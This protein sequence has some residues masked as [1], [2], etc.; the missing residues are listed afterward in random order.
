[1]VISFGS[2]NMDL[3]LRCDRIP[4]AGET[5]WGTSWFMN[6]G[7]KGANQAVQA[8][9]LGART[10]FIGC[11]GTDMFGRE[12]VKALCTE[13]IDVS[14][15]RTCA[16]S[17]GAAHILV[18]P[19][20]ENR[21]VAVP[22]A[23]ALVGEQEIEV[24]R[25]MISASSVLLL[26]C[27]IPLAVVEKAA[28]IAHAVGATV[29]LDPAPVPPVG[30]LPEILADVDYVM[31]NESEARALTGLDDLEAAGR[32]LLSLGASTVIVKRGAHGALLLTQREGMRHL[33]MF[34]VEA[35]DTT[36]AGDSFHGAFAA[37]LERGAA[38]D[39][40]LRWA[41]AAGALTVTR[42][43]A[44]GSMPDEQHVREFLRERSTAAG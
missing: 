6:P 31:P 22:G 4:A 26:Q 23:N 21:I 12:L 15:V 37:L 32:M 38:T 29:I 44:Q 16:G 10:A 43:G 27:E 42:P 24:L 41:A 35:V 18:E 25:R 36:A 30:F 7:G 14:G 40:A 11:I 39:E 28:R 19:S 9:R 3:V 2:V 5:V 1:M 20:G 17:S 33:P 8:V 13:G 34:S